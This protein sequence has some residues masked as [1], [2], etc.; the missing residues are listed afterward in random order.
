MRSLMKP[1]DFSFLFLC[2][3]GLSVLAHAESDQSTA[4]KAD[5]RTCPPPRISSNGDSAVFIS[6][7]RDLPT[8]S[9][10]LD[11]SSGAHIAWIPSKSALTLSNGTVV[12]IPVSGAPLRAAQM[13]AY[14][15]NH[16]HFE[17]LP[18][19]TGSQLASMP[20]ISLHASTLLKSLIELEQGI[21][22]LYDNGDLYVVRYKPEPTTY[23]EALETSEGIFQARLL[24]LADEHG[25][26]VKFLRIVQT[27]SSRALAFASNGEIYHVNPTSVQLPLALLQFPRLSEHEL[28]CIDTLPIGSY[29][30]MVMV[31]ISGSIYSWNGDPISVPSLYDLSGLFPQTG[32]PLFLP[33][34]IT[35]LGMN[36][37]GLPVAVVED[38]YLLLVDSDGPR[39]D[40]KM[41]SFLQS[42]RS[43]GVHLTT[44]ALSGTH[45]VFLL[46]DGSVWS[47]FPQTPALVWSDRFLLGWA[48]PSKSGIWRN[49]F[50][51]A[52]PEGF[53]I[54]SIFPFVAFETTPHVPALSSSSGLTVLQNSAPQYSSS[55][56]FY[57][58]GPELSDIDQICVQSS[59]N[60]LMIL[61]GTGKLYS[62]EAA[63]PM[64]RPLSRPSTVILVDQRAF[65]NKSITHIGCGSRA[66]AAVL[67]DGSVGIWGSGYAPSSP[68]HSELSDLSI[69]SYVRIYPPMNSSAPF[70]HV[71]VSS[72][73][74]YLIDSSGRLCILQPSLDPIPKCFQTLFD[75]LGKINHFSNGW[76]VCTKGNLSSIVLLGSLNPDTPPL[77][78][79]LNTSFA[80][81]TTLKLQDVRSIATYSGIALFLTDSGLY[82]LGKEPTARW[83]TKDGAEGN[84][85]FPTEVVM[86]GLP[87][88]QHIK[89]ITI[90]SGTLFALTHAGE[91]LST[92]AVDLISRCSVYSAQVR[93][94]APQYNISLLWD[95]DPY[96]PSPYQPDYRRRIV[97]AKSTT[98]DLSTP[99]YVNLMLGDR[100]VNPSFALKPFGTLLPS[101]HPF[102]TD[103]VSDIGLSGSWTF[104][105][106]VS[107]SNLMV[108]YSPR[109]YLSTPHLLPH[110]LAGTNVV[111]RFP[112]EN[113]FLTI[114][115]NCSAL[116]WSQVY[117]SAP[118]PGPPSTSFLDPLQ[119]PNSSTPALP[120]LDLIEVPIELNR[121]A[122]ESPSDA[123]TTKARPLHQAF[124]SPIQPNLFRSSVDLNFYCLLISE[125]GEMWARGVTD[126]LRPYPYCSS[127]LL[128]ESSPCQE[129]KQL[130]SSYE[131]YAAEL[132]S[133][134]SALGSR[135]VLDASIGFGHVLLHLND[136]NVVA[137]GLNNRGQLSRSPTSMRS[138]H[139]LVAIDLSL[140][141]VGPRAAKV[142]ASDYSSFAL[143]LDRSQIASWGSHIN[144]QLGRTISNPTMKDF[145]AF[146]ENVG[147]V[148]LPSLLGSISGFECTLATCYVLYGS[149]GQ[150]YSW[151][152]AFGGQLGRNIAPASFDPTPGLADLI[153]FPSSGG[154]RIVTEIITSKADSQALFRARLAGSF[155]PEQNPATG[156]SDCS[157]SSLPP[158]FFC[159]DGV[160]TTYQDV[161]SDSLTLPS[162]SHVVVKANLNS[163]HIVFT[164]LGS[165]LNISG[166]ANN[167]KT[168]TVYFPSLRAIE[169]KR[170]QSLVIYSSPNAEC[171]DLRNVRI[172]ANH[173]ESSCK[174]IEVQKSSSHDKVAASFTTNS[175]KCNRWWIILVSTIAG[176]ALLV[177][178]GLILL[179]AF[180]PPFRRRVLPRSKSIRIRHIRG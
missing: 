134:K 87:P 69:R 97:F 164:G 40:S 100:S 150:V 51:A 121:F 94:V 57:H 168:V 21:L 52:L 25:M 34:N 5:S 72:A 80:S 48:D 137:Y 177:I 104:N 36:S 64:F 135:T 166:C 160:W 115:Q 158:Q 68:W 32:A 127:G 22:L 33:L 75:T 155:T 28:N 141:S 117:A 176:V 133:I 53:Q 49:D 60:V 13:A 77:R 167:L 123:C 11:A 16:L 129:S 9:F 106:R 95:G 132:I 148:A 116:L 178:I 128:G 112:T 31:Y 65:G 108:L 88:T 114:H 151:G 20:N 29:R 23:V 109:M 73:A 38:E 111:A 153:V 67:E 120:P 92:C 47:Y 174:K 170:S 179:V 66:F 79:Y 102:A 144:G 169:M 8:R 6:V 19:P 93:R 165:Q 96:P 1:R 10:E 140:F 143:S 12:I 163:S 15:G 27:S 71:Y 50:G 156:S 149:H 142:I 89:S 62:D 180:H 35:Y 26:P 145:T 157:N 131:V 124:C 171:K 7:S 39:I 99:T 130:T 59:T 18:Y 83:F 136:K 90:D 44:I 172:A 118:Y 84:Y 107:L 42:K 122:L 56:N 70:K 161:N 113:G 74:I 14:F 81:T 58:T 98:P 46:N 55:I 30:S 139:R 154:P 138:S 101:E 82:G 4:S 41:T 17:G 147:L 146:D 152:S 162:N 63:L 85:E 86:P 24:H 175:S 54:K 110:R 3:L 103:L 43:G 37:T 159:E 78:T 61:T 119:P 126:V 105:Y 91:L 76:M 173:S 45:I 2:L 125:T